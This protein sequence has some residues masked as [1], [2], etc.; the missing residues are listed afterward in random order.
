MP[1]EEEIEFVSTLLS[2]WKILR[3]FCRV[4]MP[5]FRKGESFIEDVVKKRDKTNLTT[6]CLKIWIEENP[7]R[8]FLC[9]V[10]NALEIGLDNKELARKLYQR[11]PRLRK[12]TIIG[13]IAC[14]LKINLRLGLELKTLAKCAHLVH[15]IDNRTKEI[16]KSSDELLGD[17]TK[18]LGSALPL[19]LTK[20]DDKD[21]ELSWHAADSA[22]ISSKES[23]Q[24][25]L[26]QAPVEQFSERVVLYVNEHRVTCIK[27]GTVSRRI[28]VEGGSLSLS[29]HGVSLII[30][31]GAIE[32]AT[33][34]L[35]VTLSLFISDT[36]I[37][38]GDQPAYVGL[39]ELLP[40]KT[41]FLKRVTLRHELTHHRKLDPDC[42][43]TQFH[44]FYGKGVD[45]LETYD[46]MG[47][48]ESTHRQ[49]TYKHM[50]LGLWNDSLQ[51]SALSFCL[52]CS[53]ITSGTFHIIISF[54][55]CLKS[56]SRRRRDVTVAISCKC[57]ENL[58][59]IRKRQKKRGYHFIGEKPLCCYSQSLNRQQLEIALNREEDFTSKFTQS[60]IMQ[61]RGH[62]L[63]H[64]VQGDTYFYLTRD[65]IIRS[66][67][68]C[69]W[70]EPVTFSCKHTVSSSGQD[71]EL[72]NPGDQI[73]VWLDGESSNGSDTRSAIY[74]C[75]LRAC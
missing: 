61:F 44:L 46:F 31:P 35:D 11:F 55:V 20:S 38:V 64:V 30:P 66:S 52:V 28:G 40:H 49:A 13:I 47:S 23:Y 33:Q 75:I 7:E 73:S 26:S 50:E 57:Q 69:D 12:S 17:A 41:Q 53:V 45:P 72:L 18:K 1:L 34:W 27:M 24:R 15:K 19:Y 74:M 8:S 2:D 56:A 25:I 67:E 65:C 71:S 48:L 21:S 60:P 4:I 54:F 63:Y 42:I 10:Y 37:Y 22:C 9:A 6:S 51:L 68:L 58:E 16:E 43:E 36:P 32:S 62:E 29:L 59:D 39:T 70:A 3:D 5:P 14:M